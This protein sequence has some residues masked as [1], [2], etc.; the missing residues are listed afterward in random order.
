MADKNHKSRTFTHFAVPCV[1]LLL[2][3]ALCCGQRAPGVQE[4]DSRAAKASPVYPPQDVTVQF[5]GKVAIVSWRPILLDS[6]SRY[7]V[8]RWD[9]NKDEQWEKIG[10]T[11]QPKFTDNRPARKKARYKVVAVD[12]YGTKS[13][14]SQSKAS[15]VV[16]S[17]MSKAVK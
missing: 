1:L 13:L 11:E 7:E 12:R 3:A 2:C 16:N 17:K 6:L 9:G 10:T 8:Y 15:V 14:L 4:Q 5:Q